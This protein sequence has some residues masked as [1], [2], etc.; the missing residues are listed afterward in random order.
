MS[1][2]ID[3]VA[4]KPVNDSIQHYLS[5]NTDSKN[6]EVVPAP[7][8][9]PLSDLFLQAGN[10]YKEEIYGFIFQDGAFES[11]KDK[12]IEKHL[13]N[14]THLMEVSYPLSNKDL[15]YLF[16]QVLEK[17]L[18][19][20]RVEM[21]DFCLNLAASDPEEMDTEGNIF[22][23]PFPALLWMGSIHHSDETELEANRLNAQTFTDIQDDDNK[24]LVPTLGD[25]WPAWIDMLALVSTLGDPWPAWINMLAIEKEDTIE[26]SHSQRFGEDNPD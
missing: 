12:D 24:F 20:I 26:F 15:H 9:V 13:K 8:P 21:H 6:Q 2:L 10:S 22:H 25:P 23:G 11:E 4:K 19:P 14:G 16:S 1:H 3:A 17:G 18:S 7:L 5:I